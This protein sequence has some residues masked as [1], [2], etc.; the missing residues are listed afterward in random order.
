VQRW[1]RPEAPRADP[2]QPFHDDDVSD[3][4]RGR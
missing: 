1:Q 2:A 4:G 3:I